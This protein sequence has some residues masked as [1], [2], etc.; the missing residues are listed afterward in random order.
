MLSL[1]WQ[2]GRKHGGLY[3]NDMQKKAKEVISMKKSSKIF[4]ALT[5]VLLL[6]GAAVKIWGSY[7]YR[8][9]DFELDMY[10][11]NDE[12]VHVVV[13]GKVHRKYRGLWKFEGEV[14]VGDRVF[15]DFPPYDS[16]VP[17]EWVQ[18]GNHKPFGWTE[19]LNCFFPIDLDD[20]GTYYYM[21]YQ[22]KG[23]AGDTYLGSASSKEEYDQ[24]DQ[25]WEQTRR[26]TGEVFPVFP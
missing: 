1:D 18:S 9:L 20:G 16:L 2:E 11:E 23:L 24:I 15:T 8:V 10:G 14:Q 13:D 6:V 26:R 22:M 5:I 3:E 21:T 4:I 12:V 25:I 19:W 17:L 7:F